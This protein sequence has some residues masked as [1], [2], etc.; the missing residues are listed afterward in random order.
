M[1]LDVLGIKAVTNY[2]A[3]TVILLKDFS[4][5]LESEENQTIAKMFTLLHQC[6]YLS[7]QKYIP[8]A[9]RIFG[10]PLFLPI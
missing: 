7:L 6:K 8:T 2:A 5:Q 3:F 10:S 4:S 1:R 9:L